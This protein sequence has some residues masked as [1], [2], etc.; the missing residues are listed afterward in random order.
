MGEKKLN[1]LTTVTKNYVN[2]IDNYFLATL[3]SEIKDMKVLYINDLEKIGSQNDAKFFETKKLEMLCKEIESNL[4]DNIFFIDGDV[5]FAYGATFKD[6]INEILEEYDIAFQH[7]DD[8]YNF[9]VFAL[10]CNERTLEYFQHMLEIEMPKTFDIR[11]LHDQHIANALLGVYPDIP[12]FEYS[13]EK[14]FDNIKHINLP[15]R[16]FGN[17]YRHYRYPQDVPDD[18]VFIHATSTSSMSEK[19]HLLH[20]FKHK[21][22]DSRK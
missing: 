11:K 16:Y 4:G 20:D 10:S 2:L 7:N 17:H 5:V 19:I 3:P 15:I 21:Y 12:G 14:T 18:V 13:V 1:I 22:Y 6:E 9:G 8:W